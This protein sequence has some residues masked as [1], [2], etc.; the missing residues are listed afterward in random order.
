[1]A[2]RADAGPAQSGSTRTRRRF[3]GESAAAG[4]GLLA[5]APLA[6]ARSRA[7]RDV[8]VLGAGIAGLTAAHELAERGY[9]VTV[10]E[11]GSIG[12]KSRSIFVRGS[13]TNGRR[14]LPGEHG[15]RL[16]AGFYQ[17]LPDTMRRIPYGSN[18][19]GV[20][21]NLVPAGEVRLARAGG[22]ADFTVPWPVVATRWTPENMAQTIVSALEHGSRI[23]PTELEHFARKLVI[24]A[25][26]SPERCYGQWEQTSWWDYLAADRFSDDYRQ[27][28]A[29]T[30]SRST[31][32]AYAKIASAR[33]F[34]S[35]WEQF[36]YAA[37]KRNPGYGEVVSS[38]NG[39]TSDVWL[40]PWVAHLK[41]LGVHFRTPAKV[42]SLELRRGLIRSAAIRGPRGR[43]RVAADWF[44]CALPVEK[45]RKLWN[46]AIL[47]AAPELEVMRRIRTEWMSGIQFF[48]NRR[49]E[50]AQ[51]HVF[52]VDSPWAL[53]SIHQQQLWPRHDLAEDFGDGRVR[54][55]LSVVISN[56]DAPGVVYGKPAKEL[57][58]KQIAREVWTQMKQHVNDAGRAELSEDML[59]TWFVAPTVTPARPGRP[60]TNKLPLFVTTVGSWYDRPEPVT[61]VPNLFLASDYVRST[62]DQATMEGAC[63]S[64]RSAVGGLLAA[65][66]SSAA[67]PRVFELFH[68]PEL[69]ALR[70]A[71]AELYRRG[72]PHTLDTDL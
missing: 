48:L 71:D 30:W 17:N 33:S 7:R 66:G 18:P 6:G 32:A 52:Y 13:G 43:E 58:P 4:A 31:Q 21:D 36:I 64:A 29:S 60:A 10:Y 2:N 16:V 50:S 35:M 25:T 28:F 57:L 19:N 45:A 11:R 1:M 61:A 23:P 63:E 9:R 67:P 65:A 41:R 8:A 72:H 69:D 62:I 59:V 20:H 14:D 40:A 26:S 49:V 56:W 12:G 5:A 34:A 51:G 38:L 3:L 70:A 39:P 37:A 53:G 54:E 55:C 42:E 68:P 44:V 24:F 15:I 22:R 46:P 47:T 27:I